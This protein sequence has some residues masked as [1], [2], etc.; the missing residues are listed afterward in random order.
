[1]KK[2][3]LIALLFLSA[4]GSFAK[5][6]YKVEIT[7]PK[8]NKDSVV[9]LAHYLGKGLPTIFKIDSTKMTP[10]RK[11]VFENKDSVLGGIYLVIYNKNTQFVEFLLNNGDHFSIGIDQENGRP[12]AIAKNSPENTRYE[13]YNKEMEKL[14]VVNKEL[15]EK[16]GLAKSHS[17]TAAIQSQFEKLSEAQKLYRKQYIAQYPNTLLTKIFSALQTPEIPS[18]VHYLEDGKT[19]DSLFGYTYFKK[20]YWDGFDFKDDRLINTPIYDTKLNEYFKNWVYQI[21][22]TINAEADKILAATKNS[23]ELFHYTLR[24][25][26]TNALQS[27]VMGMDEVFVYLVEHYYMQGAAFWINE[28]DLKW[29]EDRARKIKG[30]VLGNTAPELAMQDI[31][32]LKEQPLSDVQAKYTVVIFWEYDCPVCKKE[33]P[34]V[35]SVYNA[36]LKSKGVKVY[37]VAI[38]RELEEMQQFVKKNKIEE[39][40]NVADLNATT[41]YRELYDAYSAPKIYLLDENK[42]IIGKGLDHSNILDVIEFTERKKKH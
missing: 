23:K 29:Y 14:S 42:K 4:F 40:I 36:V 22:D 5:K 11:A 26:T 27:K 10:D 21:P 25:L 7:L 1:M 13:A 41:N 37:S 15:I 6:G 3:T 33:V 18:G 35:D 12:R 24:T 9:Y 31:F 19:I 34:Q 38:G 39:W 20:H 2:T 32:T 17:D 28:K 8:E 30:N 16:L